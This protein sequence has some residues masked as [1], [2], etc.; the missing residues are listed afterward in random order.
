MRASR[1]HDK[2]RHR[3]GRP[4]AASGTLSRMPDDESPAAVRGLD[5]RPR[6]SEALRVA[7]GT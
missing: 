1:H 5:D 7:Q 6:W 3:T 2:Q 4:V